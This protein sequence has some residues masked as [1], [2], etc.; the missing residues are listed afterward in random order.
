MKRIGAGF[1]TL[2]T[3]GL[4]LFVLPG[5][6]TRQLDGQPPQDGR[7][8]GPPGFGQPGFGPPGD[9]PLPTLPIMAALD[10]NGDGEIS[11]DEL[12]R[13]SEALRGL[14]KNTDTKLTA[15]E[16]LPQFPGFP[17]GFGGPG[18]GP[19]GFGGP[20]GPGGANRE[21]VDQF[22]KDG[23]G[24][25][26]EA[27][28]AAAKAANPP[29]QGGFGG[30]GGR[31]GPG[32]PGGRGPG[33]TREPAKPGVK[34]SVNEVEKFPDAGLYDPNVLR[35]IFI[36]FDHEGWEDE[37]A[38]FNNTDVEVPATLTVDGKKYPQVGIHFRGMS[39]YMMVPAGYKRSFNV[40]LD[41]VDSDQ[42]LYGYKTLN[43]L[44]ANGDASFMSSALYS[45]IANQY[46]SAPKAN[47][48]RVVINGENWGV[49]VNVQQFNK[50]FLAENFGTTSGSRWKVSG[51]PNADGGL[52]YTG[53]NISEYRRRYQIKS[54]DNDQA[55]KELIRLCKTLDETPADQLEEK[56]S[57]ILDIDGALWFLAL[58]CA[59]INSDGYW[60]RA[61]DYS[62]YLDDKHQ[63]HLVPHDMNEAFHGMMGPGGPG[64]RRGG[65]GGG[66]GGPG[67]QRPGGEGGP[68]QG[69]RGPGG[70]GFGGSFGFGPPGGSG[71]IEL[72]PLVGLT[73]S[74][75]PLRSKLLQSPALK[76][77]YLR[78]VKTIAERSLTWDKLG[79]IIK[80]TREL[81]AKDIEID[82][83][84]LTTYEAFMN[85][86]ADNT[87]QSEG[88]REMSLRSFVDR[89]SEYLLKHPEISKVESV[90]VPTRK[91][92]SA[93][94]SKSNAKSSAKP[95]SPSI[96][97]ANA[98]S[99]VISELLAGNTKSSKNPQGKFEDYIELYNVTDT[100]ID[101]SGMHLSDDPQAPRKW[102]FP[103]GTTLN[104]GQY[105]VV[106]ADEKPDASN[107]LHANFKLSSKGETVLLVDTDARSNTVLDSVQYGPQTNDVSIG[108]E[109]GKS[110]KLQPMIPTAGKEN[111]LRE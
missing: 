42:R 44:N 39:S 48:V 91:K 108:R 12:D 40:A 1:V 47:F 6:I 62:I 104:A 110:D 56:L 45:H 26:N 64:G 31:G 24:R 80:S 20:G 93:R 43:L 11:A 55:W 16:I 79:P 8:Q 106:W 14:D 10:R 38:A 109:H 60:V 15:D 9:F 33:G 32:G 19:G 96:K 100:P 92:P 53:D 4:G 73:D 74:N 76:E 94:D 66:P 23:D 84:K 46:I 17:G 36:D 35:T 21:L 75:K 101:L 111:R 28:R 77:K 57:P 18:G 63:F 95:E 72:D 81:I 52:R 89:R 67:G 88:S 105:L 54:N 70:G 3:L 83:R 13:A 49:Y 7:E 85:V 59:L 41:F 102:R 22:D 25:L 90:D 37:L 69:P 107:G 97:R 2:C 68:E 30:P 98:T 58:D 86:T 78:Y 27:E 87:N 99:I 103:E 61:S 5:L 50:D 71:G 82:T 65:P 34:M 29:R 51:S